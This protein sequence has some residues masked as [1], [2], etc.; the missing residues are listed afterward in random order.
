MR[1]L[2]EVRRL[3]ARHRGESGTVADRPARSLPDRAPASA[4]QKSV[5]LASAL[6]PDDV[7]YNLCLKFTFEGRID[8]EALAGAFGDLV[9]RHEVLRTTYHADDE[10]ALHPVGIHRGA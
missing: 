8:A 3:M 7:S 6:D 9:D 4:A 5:W 2:E 1:D 10:G